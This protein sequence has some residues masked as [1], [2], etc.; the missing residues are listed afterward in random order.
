MSAS[1][2]SSP[3]IRSHRPVAVRVLAGLAL[4]T[5]L[6]VSWTGHGNAQAPSLD[7]LPVTEGPALVELTDAMLAELG[8][9]ERPETTAPREFDAVFARL[10]AEVRPGARGMPRFD[11]GGRL[12]TMLD[13]PDLPPLEPCGRRAA[14]V[15]PD[16]RPVHVAAYPAQD[17]GRPAHTVSRW[18]FFAEGCDTVRLVSLWILDAED[19]RFRIDPVVQ[20]RSLIGFAA[21]GQ[22]L[23][24]LQAAGRAALSCDTLELDQAVPFAYRRPAADA[25]ADWSEFWVFAGC[26]G[27]AG[28][29]VDL[30]RDGDG[31][32]VH[33]IAPVPLGQN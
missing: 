12:R 24:D 3:T 2:N 8:F 19:G 28:F 32:L 20:D 21:L 15:G 7:A 1:L 14:F 23:V 16:A 29:R 11:I 4:A 5:L 26:G 9:P 6:T 30:T 17:D 18:V 27:R 33:A 13:A 22:I 10:L 31:R 25:R